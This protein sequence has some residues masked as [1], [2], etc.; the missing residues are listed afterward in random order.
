MLSWAF[1]GSV[2]R[3]R[4]TYLTS[5]MVFDLGKYGDKVQST[6]S[7]LIR[8]VN[9]ASRLKENVRRSITWILKII[10]KKVNRK[11]ILRLFNIFFSNL[12]NF[13]YVYKQMTTPKIY[14]FSPQWKIAV[15]NGSI[16][17]NSNREGQASLGRSVDDQVHFYL[18]YGESNVIYCKLEKYGGN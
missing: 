12:E 18:I 10:F 16:Y 13:K 15:E 6:S 14:S 17:F 2:A 7:G 5:Q 8:E 11:S 4:F 3:L 9:T 1:E